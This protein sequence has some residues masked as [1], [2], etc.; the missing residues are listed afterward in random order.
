MWAT[1]GLAPTQILAPSQSFS[2][3]KSLSAPLSASTH[4]SHLYGSVPLP[5]ET[6]L[7]LLA[8]SLDNFRLSTPLA[9]PPEP[10]NDHTCKNQNYPQAPLSSPEQ[11]FSDYY[12]SETAWTEQFC[13]ETTWIGQ[14]SLPNL[15]S[16]Q[17]RLCP[18]QPSGDRD[19]ELPTNSV[20]PLPISS[21]RYPNDS[22]RNSNYSKVTR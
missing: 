10:C 17:E 7:E 19:R 1:S 18:P 14:S 16:P 5:A 9:E 13:D 21:R 22:D 8:Y 4:A 11:E 2:R 3:Y 20:T 12:D 6:S 15:I